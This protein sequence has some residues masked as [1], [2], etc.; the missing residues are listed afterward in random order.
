MSRII[1][2]E[3]SY[4]VGSYKRF[5]FAVKSA[6][7]SFIETH[8]GV[9]L[10]DLYGGHAVVGLGH[11]NKTVTSAIK[12]Q[13]DELTFYSNIVYSE[14]RGEAAKALC[15]LAPGDEPWKCFFIN[16]G[17]EANEN[18]LKIARMK[19]GK[20]KIISFHGGF[21]GRTA[22]SIA[23][24][25]IEKVRE[26]CQPVMPDHIHLPF[27][28]LAA[29]EECLA[30]GDVA[31]IIIEPIQSMAG[32]IESEES[33]YKG[34]SLLCDQHESYLIYDEV[35]TGLGRTGE[36]FYA[37]RHGV[38]PHMMTL[39][40][41]IA[42]GIPMGAVLFRAGLHEKIQVGDLGSTFGGGPIACAAM[43]ATI[44]QI[45]QSLLSHVNKISSM[46][47]DRCGTIS[48]IKSVLGR[49]MLLGVQ[50]ERNEAKLVQSSLLDRGVVTGLSNDPYVLRLLPPLNLSESEV[51]LFVAKMTEVMNNIGEEG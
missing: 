51:E 46:I 8:E 18:A 9:K 17:S 13:L 42:N 5:P 1:D 27:G 31:G 32:I 29:V 45:D 14:I 25:G 43:K 7:G 3:E 41:S 16:S 24:T 30:H 34:L 23:A 2:L 4:E 47:K 44:K 36:N 48:G 22:A 11:N 49:G 6:A 19:S 15:D 39:G 21:H 10:L 28:E 12:K 38:I 33:F 37:G 40:K 26:A 50:L 35:Q 20:S